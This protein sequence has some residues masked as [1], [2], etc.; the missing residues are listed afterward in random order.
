MKGNKNT[1]QKKRKRTAGLRCSVQLF[2]V[3]GLY[4]SKYHCYSKCLALFCPEALDMQ[5]SA[6]LRRRPVS[7]SES[8][9]GRGMAPRVPLCC[10]C[11]P[12]PLWQAG[13][14]SAGCPTTALPPGLAPSP[15]DP[16]CPAGNGSSRTGQSARSATGPEHSTTSSCSPS[17][18]LLSHKD[19]FSWKSR[20]S[21]FLEVTSVVVLF[22]C[23][24]GGDLI[25]MFSPF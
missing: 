13:G 19:H 1:H 20:Q 9:W 3:F 4:P 24:G 8:G 14:R 6:R 21:Y 10:G 11:P 15:M 17:P 12:T 18:L 22:F 2:F 5:C 16:L 7:R 25:V 23:G